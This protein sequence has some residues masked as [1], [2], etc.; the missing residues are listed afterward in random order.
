MV[1]VA[2]ARSRRR[3]LGIS[4]TTSPSSWSTAAARTVRRGAGRGAPLPGAWRFRKLPGTSVGKEK[5]APSEDGF[6]ESLGHDPHFLAQAGARF[7]GEPDWRVQSRNGA[8]TNRTNIFTRRSSSRD[9]SNPV[10]LAPNSNELG[11]LWSIPATC[12][13]ISAGIGLNL[14]NIDQQLVE[15]VR[16]S[17]QY[18][19]KFV[20]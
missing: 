9:P 16:H 7:S 8:P 3:R 15:F 20:R 5:L 14:A 1:D 4:T 13:L 11:S 6:R 18:R 2:R 17:D 12:W 19:L 10:E